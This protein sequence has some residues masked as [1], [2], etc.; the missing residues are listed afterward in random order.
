MSFKGRRIKAWSLSWWLKVWH[1]KRMKAKWSSSIV[2][3]T[4]LVDRRNHEGGTWGAEATGSLR[5]SL[6][7]GR[8]YHVT[9]GRPFGI[10]TTTTTTPVYP[11]CP[12]WATFGQPNFS[13]IV[14]KTA[15]ILYSIFEIPMQRQSFGI[16]WTYSDLLFY[17]H[18]RES[19]RSQVL[20]KGGINHYHDDVTTGKNGLHYWPFC[21]GS[22]PVNQSPVMFYV[23][24]GLNEY[25]SVYVR[26]IIWYEVIPL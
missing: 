2:Q 11:F 21:E 26:D 17:G 15:G 20:C 6:A 9:I 25:K 1:G 5:E 22:Q 4:L 3:G 10:Y 7:W 12:S 19:Q 8:V 18:T 13:A 14:L 16:L 24:T 23:L